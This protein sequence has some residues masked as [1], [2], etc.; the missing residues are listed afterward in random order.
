M[1]LKAWVEQSFRRRTSK[2][3]AHTYWDSASGS[4]LIS[5]AL[6]YIPEQVW[7]DDSSA[8]GL[9]S[10]GGGTSTLTARPSWQTGVTGIASE[11][12][13]RLVPDISLDSSPNNAGY[14]YCSERFDCNRHHGQLLEWLPRQQ[15]RVSHT[16]AGGASS[17]A[18]PIF[19]GMLAIIGQKENSTGLGLI[20]STLYT[21]AGN[22]TTYASAF[23][24]ITSGTNECT[25]GSSYSNT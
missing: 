22:S 21:L 3:R 15:R 17:F 14:L 23:H 24:D 5:S 2:R 18:A 20:N 8:D 9:S 11:A 16:V 7:N 13:Y 10:G 19:A 25:A 12:S 6:S 4:D 1:L